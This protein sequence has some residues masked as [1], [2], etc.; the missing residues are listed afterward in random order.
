VTSIEIRANSASATDHIKNAWGE[1]SSSM[2]LLVISMAYLVQ[3][4]AEIA[5]QLAETREK[6]DPTEASPA[7]NQSGSS[8][9]TASPAPNLPKN[10]IYVASRASIPERGAMWRK[11]RDNGVP[12]SSSWIDE[13]GAGQSLMT[14][15]W[16]R[17]LNEVA[18][19]TAL[20]LY[21]VRSDL[22]LKGAFVE[23][24]A[25]LALGKR[26]YLVT[27]D[28]N[29]QVDRIALLGS[30]VEHPNVYLEDS[31]VMACDR[32]VRGEK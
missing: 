12:I 7:P 9:Q 19:C 6:P 24:G 15:L 29:K 23:V 16:P 20:V 14:E 25:A 5:A 11:L 18:N 10:A 21:V 4:V 28:I 32:I 17:I 30:W 22:P 31:I 3:F 1:G 2:E 26:V 8:A 13:D 27:P